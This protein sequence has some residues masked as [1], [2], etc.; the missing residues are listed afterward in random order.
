LVLRLGP[1]R[2]KIRFRRFKP[3]RLRKKFARELRGHG[4]EIG[5]LGSPFRVTAE[6][7]VTY[8]DRFSAQE[9][10]EHNPGVPP[11]RLVAPDLVSD[12]TL[13]AEIPDASQDFV[14][15]SHVLEHLDDP[16]RALFTWRRVLRPGGQLLLVVPD[17]RF[18]FDRG[19][20]LTTLEHLLWDAAHPGTVE[21]HESDLQHV[22]EFEATAEPRL[23]REQALARARAVLAESY[24][25]HFHVWT[26]TT[27]RSHLRALVENHE[28]RFRIARDASDD[29]FEMIFLLEAV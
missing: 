9:L 8:V 3:E 2:I 19:R 17:A 7:M 11:E 16:V 22:A 5:A 24:D 23:T 4:I 6:A 10:R 29:A 20:A 12:A 14:I 18:T 1:L 13:L 27:F 21:K 25:S 28:L 26:Y 15:A